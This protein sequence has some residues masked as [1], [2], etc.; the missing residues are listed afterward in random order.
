[1]STRLS[2]IST[3]VR[4]YLKLPLVRMT[5]LLGGHVAPEAM[6]SKAARLFTTPFASSRARAQSAPTLGAREDDLGIDG[7]ALHTYTWG[8]PAT[9]PYV[10]FA[11]GWSSH[12]TRVARWV[13]PLRDAGYAVVTFDQAAHGRSGGTHTTLPDL[14]ISR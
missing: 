12:G 7:I 5:F 2:I 8:D 4:D 11:H 3:T 10:L 13:Q 6:A 9:Q 1:M 14:A